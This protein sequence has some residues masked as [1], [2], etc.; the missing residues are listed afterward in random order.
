MSE[1]KTLEEIKQVYTDDVLGDVESG[2]WG[3]RPGLLM[4]C[5]KVLNCSVDLFISKMYK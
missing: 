4:I 2:F 5:W 1:E 3:F